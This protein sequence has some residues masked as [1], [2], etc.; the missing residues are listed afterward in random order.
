MTPFILIVLAAAATGVSVLLRE[1]AAAGGAVS[2]LAIYSVACLL[3]LLAARNGM[4]HSKRWIQFVG[5]EESHEKPLRLYCLTSL[6]LW[7]NAEIEAWRYRQ[8]CQE[9][10]HDMAQTS[11]A[12]GTNQDTLLNADQRANLG[13]LFQQLLVE[14]KTQ[15]RSRAA[16]VLIEDERAFQVFSYGIAGP[17]F[18]NQLTRYVRPF[19]DFGNTECFGVHDGFAS[20]SILGEF[21]AFGFRF[22]ITQPFFWKEEIDLR[23]GVVWLG[24]EGNRPPLQ[25]ETAWVQRFAA[26]IEEALYA[27]HRLSDLKGKV[28]AAQELHR[29]KT[30]V[31][32]Q[33]SHDLRS[34]LN[35]VKAVLTMLQIPAEEEEFRQAALK[36]CDA[37]SDLIQDLLDYSRHRL[38]KL[39]ARA[40]AI[41]IEDLAREVVIGFKS[42]A[43][44]KGLELRL[45]LNAKDSLIKADRNHIRRILSN[46]LSNAVK[47]TSEG[48]VTVMLTTDRSR[49]LCQMAVRDTG[50]GMSSEDQKLLFTPFKRFNATSAEGIGLG[51]A[52]TRVLVEMNGGSIDA[53]SRQ[54]EGSE[55]RVRFPSLAWPGRVDD[56]GVQGVV[57]A[58]DLQVRGLRVL[59]IDDDRESAVTF[60]RALRSYGAE[61]SETSG[62]EEA[63]RL[64]NA[65]SFDAVISDGSM[66][67]GGAAALLNFIQEQALSVPVVVVTGRSEN[68]ERLLALGAAAVFI[69]PVEIPHVV[70]CLGQF[71][72]SARSKVA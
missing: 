24:Y 39:E 18:E 21:A 59:V 42:S 63:K 68:R 40:E 4:R 9:W 46:L 11:A 66:P 41:N 44:L 49:Q 29:E 60:S 6:G 43:Q 26:R 30:E 45:E 7:L 52:L 70:Q 15:F 22:V 2:A 12:P 35:N 19:F 1:A 25:N 20:D 58:A 57:H 61:T 48:S 14:A 69:K 31:I 16:A 54:G 13:E 47:Y 71:Q 27:F 8:S 37:L 28:N 32:A 72:A 10:Q 67:G 56:A 34:P 36:N 53:I 64:L 23:R 33:M 17:R 38:G 55:F 51:L 5:D 50:V 65:K 62:V 3:D